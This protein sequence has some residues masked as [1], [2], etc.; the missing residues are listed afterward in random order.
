MGGANS[1]EKTL[2][3]FKSEF[4]EMKTQY[5]QN[6]GEFV[7]Y[8]K[9]DDPDFMV[10]TKERFM[11]DELSARKF[12]KRVKRRQGSH[13]ENVAKLLTIFQNKT[14]SWCSTMTKIT[15]IYEYHER[16]LEQLIRHRKNYAADSVRVNFKLLPKFQIFN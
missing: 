4:E 2:E 13:G 7:V 5:D 1:H 8:R 9:I 11:N 10:M 12:L 15:L 6:F 3:Q 16:T 14:D